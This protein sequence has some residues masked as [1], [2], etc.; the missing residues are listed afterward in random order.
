MFAFSPAR[1][2]AAAISCALGALSLG[3]A[4]VP[5]ALEVKYADLVSQSAAPQNG[6]RMAQAMKAG[7]PLII[8]FQRGD[9]L[10]V[11]LAISGEGFELDAQHPALGLIATRHI[12]LRIW[13]DGFRLSPDPNDF[14]KPSQPGSFRVG[15]GM[16]RSKPPSLN[17]E[18]VGPRH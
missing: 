6:A 3:C 15:F 11:E 18:L 9:R 17:I 4:H 10:P 1:P 2:A 5:P 14:S 13:K 16:A 8:E 12:Y 7:A